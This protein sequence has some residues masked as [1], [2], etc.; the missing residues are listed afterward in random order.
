MPSLLSQ[1][2]HEADKLVKRFEHHDADP[3]Y[4]R[5]ARP[6]RDVAEAFTAKAR[7]DADLADA[8][9][10]AR[11]EGFSWTSIG[12]MLETGGE[13]ARQRYGEPPSR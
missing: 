6:L 3:G 12:E 10:V 4:I 7:L 8:V 5:D 1:I 2:L 11:A 9:A 13:A